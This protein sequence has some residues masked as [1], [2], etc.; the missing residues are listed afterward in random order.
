MS[1]EQ[2]VAD[3]RVELPVLPNATVVG[4][5][6]RNRGL[7]R[8]EFEAR[9]TKLKSRPRAIFVEL[10]RSCNLSCPMCREP[11][12]V[13]G[14]QRMAE[15]LFSL[16]EAE[17][18]ASA[19]LIDLRGWGESL[20]LPEFPDR[21]RRAGRS[22]ASLRVVTNLSFRRDGVL[23]LLAELGFYVGV[24]LDTVDA[25][26]L[27]RI[28]RGARLD[29][30]ESNLI[31]LTDAYRRTGLG[32]R[33]NLYVTCQLPAL[34]SL[35]HVISFAADVGVRDVRLAPVTV[36][37]SSSLCL[38][39]VGTESLRAC[40]ER[41]RETGDRR[42]VKVSLTA[43]LVEGL[44]PNT[45]TGAC[46]HPWDWCYIAY[47]GRVGFCDHLI[48]PHGDPFIM[49]DLGRQTFEE[50]WNS[51]EWVALRHEHLGQRRSSA[52]LFAE[53]SW[54]YRN[55]HL[56]MEDILEPSLKD[57]RV[58]LESIELLDR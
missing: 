57:R 44:V 51:P 23:D 55:R 47:D 10:T 24:S 22:G 32:D 8:S 9:L 29:V 43:S 19:D 49:G 36:E 41:V 30:I 54:C 25:E 34:D 26:L 45:E 1:N 46:L 13:P 18:F 48:G 28:R 56:D 40:L 33:I 12:T 35:D 50:I 17:L 39:H 58:R 16:I 7:S 14:S 15:P 4:P 21:A 52:P 27:G 38:S 5:R 2:S 11:G 31:R 6:E 3:S 53:C 20:I 37:E 42:G